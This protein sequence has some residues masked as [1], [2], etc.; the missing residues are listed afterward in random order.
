MNSGLLTIAETLQNDVVIYRMAAMQD[1]PL[2]ERVLQ[3]TL[4]DGT[5]LLEN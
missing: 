4:P 5:F 3:F 2:A 1:E